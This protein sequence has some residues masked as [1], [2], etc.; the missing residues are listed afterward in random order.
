MELLLD[1]I[2]SPEITLEVNRGSSYFDFLSLLPE[3]FSD[4][5]ILSDYMNELSVVAG[6]WL[7][8]STN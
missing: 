8:I 7:R 5:T 6:S 2:G 4:S 1:V 3:H